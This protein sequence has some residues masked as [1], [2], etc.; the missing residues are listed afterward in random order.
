M[1]CAAKKKQSPIFCK[2]YPLICNEFRR[3]A[4]NKS[5]A[6]FLNN[7]ALEEKLVRH[8]VYD[9]FVQHARPPSAAQAAAEFDTS[10]KDMEDVYRHLSEGHFF[11]LKPN[12]LDILMAHPFS[13]EPTSFQVRAS[14]QTYWANCAWDMLGIPAALH[15][16][17][18]IEAQI[19]GE[20]AS[21]TIRVKNGEVLHQGELV[22][23]ALPFQRWYDDLLLT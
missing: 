14:R 17:A 3:N 15:E 6:P 9:Y 23:F 4:F 10:L 18:V 7:M 2:H 16:D 22:H 21:T 13:A 19:T 5:L 12:T 1:N 8:F 11:F 20:N